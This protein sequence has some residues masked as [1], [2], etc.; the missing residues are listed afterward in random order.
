[1][2]AEPAWRAPLR[3]ALN[4]AIA[5]S[6]GRAGMDY[7]A[8]GAVNKECGGNGLSTRRH[9]G[10]E[11]RGVKPKREI[12][13]GA[14][15]GGVGTD[16]GAKGPAYARVAHRRVRPLRSELRPPV[17]VLTGHYPRR[18]YPR[19]SR[20]TRHGAQL[21]SS[22]ARQLENVRSKLPS[23]P[24]SI[25]SEPSPVPGV[26]PGRERGGVALFTRRERVVVELRP[27][28]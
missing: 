8:K 26:A 9:G 3:G 7:G 21:R 22:G 5:S 23:A 28:G 16:Y 17:S 4:P 2:L 12:S 10:T 25:L 20:L 27:S 6:P 19:V 14:C 24:L 13:S 1:M 11:L 18:S 15:P